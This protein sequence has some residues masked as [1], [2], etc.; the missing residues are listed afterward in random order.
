MSKKKKKKPIPSLTGAEQKVFACLQYHPKHIDFLL[1]ETQLEY[2]RL[3]DTLD[4]LQRK[5]VIARHGQGYYE[6][7]E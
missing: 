2:P 5:G 3:L 4:V 7:V 6:K 1:A